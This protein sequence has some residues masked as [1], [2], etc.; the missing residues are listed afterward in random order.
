MLILIFHHC[1]SEEKRY[2]QFCSA[3][4]W[5]QIFEKIGVA[6]YYWYWHWYWHLPRSI[7]TTS[8]KFCT[9]GSQCSWFL[10]R[11]HILSGRTRWLSK[12]WGNT[13]VPCFWDTSLC[14]LCT[15]HTVRLYL[16]NLHMYYNVW[17]HYYSTAVSRPLCHY[18]SSV[19]CNLKQRRLE[20]MHRRREY[21][22]IVLS[23]I[24][25]ALVGVCS[26]TSTVNFTELHWSNSLN[27]SS[28]SLPPSINWFEILSMLPQCGTH[29]TLFLWWTNVDWTVETAI[30]MTAP[31][32]D[33][34]ASGPTAD[35]RIW[36]HFSNVLGLSLFSCCLMFPF[37]PI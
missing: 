32:Y 9:G 35:C 29:T 30:N 19:F 13:C 1:W 12:S 2:H 18:I 34:C 8:A 23:T 17:L 11:L 22:I 31:P 7:D 37:Y 20:W 24:A 3:G 25:L 5:V 15:L 10:R 21:S 33:T 26:S 14:A 6:I 16:Q 28:R 36:A 4:K 27:N